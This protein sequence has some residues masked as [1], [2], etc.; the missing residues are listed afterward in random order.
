MVEKRLGALAVVAGFL[1]RLDVAGAVDRACPVGQRALSTHGQIIEAL[2]AN[3]LTS[4]LPL[5]HVSHWARDWAVEEVFGLSADILNDGRLA[6]AL[7]AIAP[8]LEGIVGSVGARAIDVSGLGVTRLHWDMTSMSLHGA[9]EE[10]EEDCPAPAYGH[11]RDR[12][13][14][15]KQ[16]Q[17]GLAVTGDGGV[18]VFHRAYA[19]GA[20]EVSQVT[21]AMRN[22][23]AMAGERN[24]LLVGDSNGVPRSFRTGIQ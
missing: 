23:S 16:I 3:R 10:T 12:R 21:A 20:A 22:L 24:F 9:Y 11:P 1:R 14:D 8:N 7:D 18:P 6:R 13:T 2:V 17:A 15:L 19:G 5:Q 4:P